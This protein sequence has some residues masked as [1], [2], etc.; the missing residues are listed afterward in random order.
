[1]ELTIEPFPVLFGVVTD[2]IYTYVYIAVNP[3]A[4]SDFFIIF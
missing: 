1:M 4:F 3:V 2:G